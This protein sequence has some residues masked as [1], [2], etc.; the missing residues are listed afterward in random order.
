[1]GQT[2]FVL[3]LGMHRSGTSM[4]T[5]ILANA[6]YFVGEK[7]DIMQPADDNPNGFFEQISVVET[8]DIILKLCQGSWD[9]PPSEDTIEQIHINP[10]IKVVF[11]NYEGQKRVVIKDPRM[12]LTLPVWKKILPDNT[13]ILY[14]KRKKEAVVASLR[15]RNSFSE[16]KSEELFEIY[17]ERAKK[18]AEHYKT[19]ELEYEALF[20]D[21]QALLLSELNKFLN[22]SEDLVKIGRQVINPN[23]NHFNGARKSKIV[24]IIIP[25]YNK[26]KYTK[27]CLQALAK[28]T[29]Y[30]DYEIIVVDNASTDGTSGFLEE[31]R[32]RDPRIRILTN[33]KN[34]GFVM[35]NNQA[36]EIARGD[37][38]FCLNNDTEVQPGWLTP[39]VKFAEEHT[40][41]GIVGSK[42]V[43]P[44]NTL[45]EAG[46]I[47]FSDGNGWNYGRR[48]NVK[49]VRFNFI[50]EVD[51][52]SGAAILVRKSFWEKVG[53]FD[54]RYAPA[55]Y[56]DTDL[57]F[58]AR[59]EGYKVY[60]HPHSVVIHHEGKTAGTDLNSGYKKYQGINRKKFVAKWS[61]VLRNQ[62]ANDPA[63]VLAASDR[64]S[65]KNILIIDPFLPLFDRASGSFRLLQI[66]KSLKKQNFHITFI[67]RNGAHFE[68][69]QPLLEGLGIMTI[70]GDIL[71]MQAAGVDIKGQKANIR[72]DHLFK[73]R[74]YDYAI[75]DFWDLAAYYLP[76][77]RE[78]SPETKIIIDTVDVH[79]VRETRE[80][81]LKHNKNLIVK[82]L[83]NKKKELAI[84]EKADRLWV[85]TGAD[86]KILEKYIHNVPIDIIPNIH[87]KINYIR[88]YEDTADLLF[89][90]NFNH[91]PNKDA[92]EYFCNEVMPIILREIPDIKLQIVGNAADLAVSHLSGEHVAVTG[93][94]EDLSPFLKAARLS[95]S[96]LRYGAGMKGKIGE[97]FSWGLP[98]ITTSVG[99]EGMNIIDFE[100]A[101][102]AD[103]STDFA[104]KTVMAYKQKE[105][106]MKLSTGGKKLVEENWS[107]QAVH[108]NLV[109]A[110]KADTVR[111]TDTAL[112]SIIILTFNA[113]EYTRKCV[114]S[115]R[116]NTRYPYEIIFVDNASGDG[117]VKYLQELVE[118]NENYKLIRNEVNKGFAAGNNQGVAAAE[119][120]YVL[121][122]N[123][124]VLVG[125]GWLE[126]LVSAYEKNEAIGLIG[127]ITNRASGRQMLTNIPYEEEREFYPFAKKIMDLN[128]DRITPRRRIAGL[129]MLSSRKIYREIGGFDEAFGL[130]NFEDDDF[131]LK[132]SARGYAI[133]VHE[134]V[135]IH[136]FGSRTFKANKMDYSG[137][138]KEKGKKFAE[139]WP[140]VNYRELLELEN[141][142]DEVIPRWIEAAT[143]ALIDGKT[144]TALDRFTDI[145]AIDPLCADARLGLILC[146]RQCGNLQAALEQIGELLDLYPNHAGALNQSGIIAAEMGDLPGAES[147]LQTA[148]QADPQ[149]LEVRRNLADV[150]FGL[151]NYD[152]GLQLLNTIVEKSPDDISTLLKL[153]EIAANAGK[154]EDSEFFAGRVLELMP[155]NPDALRFLQPLKETADIPG[156]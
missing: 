142:L 117:T 116:K 107:P 106:W 125:E 52:C 65:E 56:E 42:L 35:A 86:K 21:E 137:S 2:E 110:F 34:L 57:C 37:Y 81:E 28:N 93:Y 88:K 79:F 138:L 74:F 26:L 105:L 47:I 140:A 16:S 67:A 82:A 95:V 27:Q 151:G 59:K 8:N 9:N 148:L 3:V 71:A 92:I 60:Y 133:M 75:L 6:G 87:P 80:A 155:D 68:K 91:P 129:A 99:A 83:K 11:Q 18:Y 103:N 118:E 70:C 121:M 149:Y 73:E 10:Q 29:K 128:R 13:K 135:Y 153:A 22:T 78:Y 115:I 134:G 55:Y 130:G 146:N 154:T 15:N 76:I 45:Q 36:A 84:Y 32:E 58:T 24:S 48:Q 104:E 126:G 124:D 17:N 139:K 123:N 113:L 39:L 94:Q 5:N 114:N 51:Y 62:K 127:P 102:V 23:L 132:I 43:Y 144:D 44:D 109:S 90:G 143:Q 145:V 97:A 147:L 96:P 53:G 1:M 72:Y 25:V 30:I 152:E 69:Y 12:C 7:K 40:D 77:I 14:I 38:L 4:L 122:L 131:C 141:P 63:N 119:G 112:V 31:A 50:R 33:Q 66:L 54:S 89:V 98:V 150:K 64:S 49:D 101:L 41:C 120:K 100:H 111:D 46:G 108:K 156:A 20:T 19:M 61:D 85:V 136:H